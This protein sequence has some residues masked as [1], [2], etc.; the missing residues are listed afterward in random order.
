MLLVVQMLKSKIAT[1]KCTSSILFPDRAVK[2]RVSTKSPRTMLERKSSGSVKLAS[3]WLLGCSS[4]MSTRCMLAVQRFCN[5]NVV[6]IL[7]QSGWSKRHYTEGA[8]LIDSLRVLDVLRKG[9][10]VRVPP[11]LPDHPLPPCSLANCR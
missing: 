1:A 3:A 4:Q 6:L 11:G 2:C 7:G 5:L 8:E 9:R 10:V